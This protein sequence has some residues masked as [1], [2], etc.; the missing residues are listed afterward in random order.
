M[1]QIHTGSL[2]PLSVSPRLLTEH[3]SPNHT[4]GKTPPRMELTKPKCANVQD[5]LTSATRPVP[6]EKGFPHEGLL[7]CMY[8]NP[9]WTPLPDCILRKR[10]SSALLGAWGFLA[11]E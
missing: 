2:F 8:T 9:T 1:S 10:N 7:L 3:Q 5:T 6:F 4:M 11:A